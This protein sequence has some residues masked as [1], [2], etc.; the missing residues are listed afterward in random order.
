MNQFTLLRGRQIAK[1][2]RGA[3]AAY[4]AKHDGALLRRESAQHFSDV[5][6]VRGVEPGAQFFPALLGN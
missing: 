3:F 5:G 2:F 4:K 1:N 6:N